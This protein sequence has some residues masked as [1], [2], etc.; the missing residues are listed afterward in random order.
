[1]EALPALDW[2]IQALVLS[3]ERQPLKRERDQSPGS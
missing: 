3:R 2:K 1:M